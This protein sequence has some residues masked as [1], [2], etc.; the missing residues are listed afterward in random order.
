VRRRFASALLPAVAGVVVDVG[1]ALDRLPHLDAAAAV[2]EMSE[3]AAGAADD[4]AAK[5]HEDG[6]IA[7]D[8]S[9]PS[10]TSSD[11]AQ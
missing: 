11:C 4:G 9:G 5:Y 8:D 7:V 1:A 10:G 2:A 3:A 6:V